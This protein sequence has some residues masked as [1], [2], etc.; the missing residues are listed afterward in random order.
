M[1]IK[2]T[3]T[4]DAKQIGEITL[5]DEE[6]KALNTELELADHKCPICGRVNT[7]IAGWVANVIKA[8]ASQKINQII[9]LTGEGSEYTPVY[10]KLEIIRKAEK[11][12]PYLLK[13]AK[14][15]QKELEKQMASLGKIAKVRD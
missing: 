7:G 15:R 5:T 3:F 11:E 9:K 4:Q 8:K 6:V 12:M 13:G 2:I 14:Q 1:P 10:K